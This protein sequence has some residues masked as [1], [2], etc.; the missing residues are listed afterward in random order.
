M[1]V[2]ESELR[3]TLQTIYMKKNSYLESTGMVY[4]DKNV[5]IVQKTSNQIGHN[6]VIDGLC[7]SIWDFFIITSTVT[8]VTDT[9][10][11]YIDEPKSNV[12]LGENK[13]FLE[14][15]V[16]IH[17]D[18][19]STS[20]PNNLLLRRGSGGPKLYIVAFIDNRISFTQKVGGLQ[21]YT[22]FR[23]KEKIELSLDDFGRVVNDLNHI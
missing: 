7:E 21:N 5:S 19:L 8:C 18:L 9:L 3:W 20:N 6:A 12:I 16:L 14:T 1:L 10:D 13:G 4:L 2:E 15:R 22:D 17:I 23:R 11:L